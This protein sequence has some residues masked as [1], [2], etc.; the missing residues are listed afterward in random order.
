MISLKNL[1]VGYPDGR[2]TRQLNHAANEEA[3]DGMLTCL[4]GANRAG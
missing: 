2:P 3:L 4:S 1:V